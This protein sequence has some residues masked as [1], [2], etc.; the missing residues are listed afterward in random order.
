MDWCKLI[1][2]IETAL[3][4]R[5]GL[6]IL[7]TRADAAMA[8]DGGMVGESFAS[9]TLLARLLGEPT[10]HPTPEHKRREVPITTAEASLLFLERT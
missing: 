6:A 1:Q 5:D 9:Q 10:L 2:S 7:K 3:D 8:V 4:V